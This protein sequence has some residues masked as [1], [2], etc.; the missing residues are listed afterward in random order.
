MTHELVAH[1]K[2]AKKVR[3]IF[4]ELYVLLAIFYIVFPIL[5]LIVTSFDSRGYIGDILSIIPSLRWYNEFIGSSFFINGIL[6]SFFV[7][8]TATVL[9]L[10][11][12]LSFAYVIVRYDFPGKS[13]LIETSMA[14]AVVPGV[15]LG[16]ALL[17]FFA[18]LGSHLT[19]L[20]III[21]HLII[22]LPYALRTL[23]ATLEGFDISI[24]E[25]ALVLGATRLRAFLEVTLPN[26]KSGIIAAAIFSFAISLDDVAVT[27]FLTDVYT[28]TFPVALLTTFRRAISPI[29]AVGCSVLIVIALCMVCAID[30]SYGLERFVGIYARRS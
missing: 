12:G 7:G 17:Y 14:P 21:A 15:T 29:A 27:A 19:I 20:N 25:A 3:N 22:T 2:L 23:I 6:T 28:Y 30:K 4:L 9:S 18:R 5:L 8:I 16:F 11:V 24:E 26:I 1:F 13:I 10:I